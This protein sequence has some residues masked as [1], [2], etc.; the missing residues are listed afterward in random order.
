MLS[1][2]TCRYTLRNGARGV[3]TILASSS[4]AA[5]ISAMDHLGDALRT[6]S[7]RPGLTSPVEVP[8]A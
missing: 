5:L 8:A 6:C 2:Y 7:A 3:L 4:C 1:A